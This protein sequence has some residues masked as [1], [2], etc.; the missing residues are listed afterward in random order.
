MGTPGLVG[1]GEMAE[2]EQKFS[3]DGFVSAP[4]TSQQT[5]SPH[6]TR[7]LLR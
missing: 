3:Q 5:P 1:N 7:V 6:S 2:L 4:C